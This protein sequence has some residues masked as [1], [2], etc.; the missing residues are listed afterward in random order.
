MGEALGDL[1][2]SAVGVAISP[3]PIVAVIL[4]L[5]TPQARTTGSAFAAGW[6]LGLVVVSVAVLVVASGADDPDSGTSTAVDVIR[7]L[8]GLLFLAL[9]ARQWHGRPRAGQAESLPPWMAAV[10]EFTSGSTA[11]IFDYDSTGEF[12]W[13]SPFAAELDP[14]SR[15]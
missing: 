11:L 3:I 2:P 8:L 13:V 15:P 9:A 1:L 5:G 12:F 7:I 4:M 6:I 14:G 10:D